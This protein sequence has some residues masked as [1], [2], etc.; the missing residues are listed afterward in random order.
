MNRSFSITALRCRY[1]FGDASFVR[2]GIQ[3]AYLRNFLT[4]LK[5]FSKMND[6]IGENLINL[7]ICSDLS[8]SQ[9]R[10]HLIKNSKNNRVIRSNINFVF[11]ITPSG[12][13]KLLMVD[14]KW[15]DHNR[16]LLRGLM[17]KHSVTA[18]N[19]RIPLPH[20]LRTWTL[21]NISKVDIIPFV[22]SIV[23]ESDSNANNFGS[24]RTLLLL[25]NV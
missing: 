10:R 19:L 1:Q 11:I 14:C 23:C 12:E 13:P 22:W 2:V 24:K 9:R 5:I 4:S 17:T 18:R 8:K 6:E 21:W 20:L 16:S 15:K 25:T 7:Q 3:V